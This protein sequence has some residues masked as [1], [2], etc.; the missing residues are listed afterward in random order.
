M[1]R[2][3]S[4]VSTNSLATFDGELRERWIRFQQQRR[5]RM[6]ND[7]SFDL[8]RYLKTLDTFFVLS[9]PCTDGLGTGKISTGKT[10]L[11]LSLFEHTPK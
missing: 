1:P 9:I 3:V 11:N 2:L 7:S 4:L 5:R 6:L 10:S 8:I